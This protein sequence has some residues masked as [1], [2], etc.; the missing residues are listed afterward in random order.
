MPM[1]DTVSPVPSEGV[2]PSETKDVPT[3]RPS[4]DATSGSPPMSV[5]EAAGMK[6]VADWT[7]RSACHSFSTTVRMDAC[8]EEA[9]T[10]AAPTSAMPIMRALAVLAVRRGLRVTL[11]RASLPSG[12][13]AA[14]NGTASTPRTVRAMTGARSRTPTTTPTAPRPRREPVP[15]SSSAAAWRTAATT[16]P[17]PAPAMTRPTSPRMRSDF[18]WPGDSSRMA[19]TGGTSAA[20][21][22]GSAAEATLTTSPTRR[23]STTMVVVTGISPERSIPRLSKSA[24]MAVTSPSPPAMPRAPPRRPTTAAWTRIDA[25]TWSGEA[26][27]ARRRANSR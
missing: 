17:V 25:N 20:R 24:L 2:V 5:T 15:A 11:P 7:M 12:R 27:T 16:A 6:N 8:V 18:P 3:A 4:A 14:T 10:D 9:S 21:R 22:A 1:I 23:E 19:S 13:I 26:P